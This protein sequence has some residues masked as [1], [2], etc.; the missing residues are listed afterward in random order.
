MPVNPIIDNSI[1]TSLLKKLRTGYFS[2]DSFLNGTYKESQTHKLFYRMLV[3]MK[4]YLKFSFLGRLTEQER[5]DNMVILDRS[6]IAQWFKKLYRRQILRLHFYFMTSRTDNSIKQLKE[7]I[8]LSPIKTSCAV[9]V[10][11]VLTNIIFSLLLKKEITISGWLIRGLLLFA[12]IAGFHSQADWPEV[13]K[14][15]IV[16]RLF[17]R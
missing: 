17:S 3:R 11:A 16:L 10:T 4:L 14:G 1:S 2:I 8:Y 7:E 15:S 12:G 13:K 5:E 6:T 9:I